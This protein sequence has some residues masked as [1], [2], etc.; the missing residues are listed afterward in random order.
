M[1]K[2]VKLKSYLQL[3]FVIYKIYKF[4]QKILISILINLI[5]AYSYFI[6]PLVGAKCRFNPT[7]SAYAI[8]A[9]KSNNI[10]KA[11]WLIIVRLAKCQPFYNEK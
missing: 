5:K 6:S 7:C 10:I 4:T 1:N 11:I 9:L 3:Y 2:Q 8:S